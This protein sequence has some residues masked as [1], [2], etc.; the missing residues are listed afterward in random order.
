MIKDLAMKALHLT[1][2][3]LVM[4]LTSWLTLSHAYRIKKNSPQVPST[5]N[6]NVYINDEDGNA[7]PNYAVRLDGRYIGDTN[8]RGN[9]ATTNLNIGNTQTIALNIKSKDVKYD[10]PKHAVLEIPVYSATESTDFTIKASLCLDYV[11]CDEDRFEIALSP[12]SNPKSEQ[13]LKNKSLISSSYNFNLIRSIDHGPKISTL[14]NEVEKIQTKKQPKNYTGVPVDVL[15][16]HISSEKYGLMVRI[17]GRSKQAETTANQFAMLLPLKP[18][19]QDLAQEIATYLSDLTPEK[20]MSMARKTLKL[21]FP[22]PLSNNYEVYAG[23]Y[24]GEAITPDSWILAVP[25]SGKFFLTILK[26]G[27]VVT[28][29]FFDA[30]DASQIEFDAK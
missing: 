19:L 13:D 9:V 5:A 30:G 29:K 14:I 10:S 4:T 16:S 25:E 20:S 7:I 3:T 27:Q 12:P 11:T 22:Q 6:F 26:Q 8:N 2:A 17:V 21:K 28:R 23:V 24:S 18:Q 1:I 15:F